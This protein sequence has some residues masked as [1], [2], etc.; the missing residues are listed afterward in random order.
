MEVLIKDKG[1]GEFC[2][3]RNLSLRDGNSNLMM[4]IYRDNEDEGYAFSVN[5]EVAEEIIKAFNQSKCLSGF[6]VNTKT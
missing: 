3:R 4:R 2:T 6:W 5:D 1:W